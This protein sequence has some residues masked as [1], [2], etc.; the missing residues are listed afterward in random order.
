MERLLELSDIEIRMGFA[1]SCVEAAVKQAGCSY[2]EMYQR[3]KRVGLI[4]KY[5]LRHYDTIHTESRENITENI[6][7]CLD[8]W[9]AKLP[10]H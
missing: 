2:K 5:I 6:L 7:E 1:A 10:N 9:E 8:N 3:M 4:N